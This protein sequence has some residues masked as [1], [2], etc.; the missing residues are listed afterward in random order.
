MVCIAT[1]ARDDG[2]PARLDPV[3]GRSQIVPASRAGA[4]RGNLPTLLT[5]YHP[6]HQTQFFLLPPVTK[7]GLEYGGKLPSSNVQYPQRRL[8]F[9]KHPTVGIQACTSQ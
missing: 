5:A 8:F 1:Q 4:V 9:L 6:R 2:Q 3:Q 7:M